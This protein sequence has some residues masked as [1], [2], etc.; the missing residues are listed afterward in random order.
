MAGGVVGNYFMVV[1]R[2][3]GA[4]PL[5]LSVILAGSFLG[6]L[7]SI[8]APYF[9]EAAQPARRVAL[10]LGL[11][12]LVWVGALFVDAPIPFT[13]VALASF[14]LM[15]VPGPSTRESSRG[16]IHGA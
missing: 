4:S 3:L 16:R 10:M 9:L 6:A 14:V 7:L 2:R 13:V 15:G 11:A 12:Q 5:L 1:A 8:A